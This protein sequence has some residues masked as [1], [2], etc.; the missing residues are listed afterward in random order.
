MGSN[1]IYLFVSHIH[2][3]KEVVSFRGAQ[4]I[5]LC[6]ALKPQAGKLQLI[7]VAVVA[8]IQDKTRAVKGI[9]KIII[10]VF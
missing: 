8:E 1:Y 5:N 9:E 6:D 10:V 4:K 2:Y 3:C 7:H